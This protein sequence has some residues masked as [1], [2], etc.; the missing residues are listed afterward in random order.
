MTDAPHS[1]APTDDGAEQAM[2]AAV[3]GLQDQVTD[4]TGVLETHQR[5]FER[6]RTAGLLPA[7]PGPARP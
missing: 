2:A 1:A 4:L 7:D 3:A 6:L 5:L